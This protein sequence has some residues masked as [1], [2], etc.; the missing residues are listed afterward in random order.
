[1]NKENLPKDNMEAELP[2]SETL[3]A[4]KTDTPKKNS[5]MRSRWKKSRHSQDKTPLIHT[6]SSFGVVEQAPAPKAEGHS[7]KV[8]EPKPKTAEV[9]P[10]KE[11]S[12]K[13][14]LEKTSEKTLEDTPRPS[15]DEAARPSRDE[16]P[17]T[18]APKRLGRNDISPEKPYPSRQSFPKRPLNKDYAPR[19]GIKSSM[20]YEPSRSSLQK[21]KSLDDAIMK[22]QEASLFEKIKKFFSRLFSGETEAKPVQ[23]P[24]PNY[25]RKNYY[26]NNRKPYYSKNRN[27]RKES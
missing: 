17:E 1:M 3:K 6:A 27:S 2:K 21:K 20:D 9:K 22:S 16:S 11:L 19:E 24:R 13:K 5:N 14:P 12:P 25:G 10:V 26:N 23:K 4:S 8:I 15:R 18:K 7:E